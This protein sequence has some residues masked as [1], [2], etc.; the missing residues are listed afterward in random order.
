[1]KI[2]RATYRLQFGREF[3]FAE[4]VAVLDYLQELGVS[5]VYSSPL[6]RPGAESTHGYDICCFEEVSPMLG[7]NA[8]FEGF[9]AAARER[10]LGILLDMVP[11]HMGGALTNRWWVDVLRHGPNSKYAHYFDVDWNPPDSSLKNKVLLPLLED[12]YGRVLEA[13]KLKLGFVDGEFS[14]D[15]YDRRFPVAPESYKLLKSAENPLEMFKNAERLHELLERQHYRLAWWRVA[16][17][18]INYRRFFDVTDLVALRMERPDVFD[19][20]HQF[21]FSLIAEGK[22]AALRIDHPDGLWDPKQYFERLQARN[23]DLYIVAEKILTGHEPLPQDWPVAGT[24][25]YDFLN[26]VNG[27]FVSAA[28]EPAF[29][30]IYEEFT[31]EDVDL[32]S[33][34]YACKKRVLEMSF[35]SE[36][37]SLAHRLRGLAAQ[38]PNGHDLTLPML[39]ETL[40]AVVAAFPVYRTYIDERTREVRAEERA[41]IEHALV[42]AHARNRSLDAVALEVVEVR[43]ELRIRGPERHAQ[44]QPDH[45]ARK[46]VPHGRNAPLGE[47]STFTVGAQRSR[48]EV[49]V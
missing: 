12:H 9:A 20:A 21:L 43:V 23:K 34:V 19:A 15:Y 36:L 4:A 2:P 44:E 30:K 6:F 35:H 47:P 27:L 33:L 7:G 14:I 3:T 41:Y 5:E 18:Q 32:V 17:Q 24:T 45:R 46:T 13:G 31:G 22:V 25:G 42:E 40:E 39:R 28:N 16:A 11:N 8:G 1:M 37:T 10:G 49:M 38:T 26:R 48:R 29:S